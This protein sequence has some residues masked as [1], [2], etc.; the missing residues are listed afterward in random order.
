M[1]FESTRA[2]IFYPHR[3]SLFLPLFYSHPLTEAMAER[4]NVQQLDVVQQEFEDPAMMGVV[5]QTGTPLQDPH[6]PM[7]S[8]L[9][10]LLYALLAATLAFAAYIC[11]ETV[12]MLYDFY[13]IIQWLGGLAE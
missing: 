1:T 9:R 13:L 5:P 10:A 3:F 8:P 11:V 6:V 12:K 2:T 4:S 7:P